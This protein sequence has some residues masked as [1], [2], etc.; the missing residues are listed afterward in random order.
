MNRITLHRSLVLSSNHQIE[1][2]F[3][4]NQIIPPHTSYISENPVQ[5][6]STQDQHHNTASILAYSTQKL[7]NIQQLSRTRMSKSCSTKHMTT[8]SHVRSPPS[9]DVDFNNASQ[10]SVSPPLTSSSSVNEAEVGTDDECL[11]LFNNQ[12]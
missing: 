5:I 3:N 1:Y 8:Q 11:I 4:T 10:Y 7:P 2:Q 6:L 9:Q 12:I